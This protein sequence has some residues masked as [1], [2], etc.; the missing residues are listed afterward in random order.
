M[1]LRRLAKLLTRGG[2]CVGAVIGGAELARRTQPSPVAPA[3][4]DAPQRAHIALPSMPVS[5]RPPAANEE[6]DQALSPER[7]DHALGIDL[8][9][10]KVITGATE[11]RL[12]LF[13]FDDGPDRRTTPLLLDRLDAEGVKAVFFLAARRIRGDNLMQREQAEIAREIV[14]RG[15]MVANHTVDHQQLPLLHDDQVVQQVVGAERIFE[16]VLGGRPWLIRPPGGARS[17]RIDALLA[18]R[19]YT[20]VMWNLGS[21]DFQ[22]RSADQVFETWRRVFERRREEE[23][24]RGGIILLHDTYTWSVDAF[25]RIV[26]Y[27]RERNCHLLRQGEEL[28]DIVDDPALFFEPREDALPGS[29][30][31]PAAPPEDILEARQA[32]LRKETARRCGTLAS[33]HPPPPA[34]HGENA[35]GRSASR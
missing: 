27:L 23:G 31:A 21:G 2:L 15:H 26:A 25:Q 33:A 19:G 8:K 13:T 22:V 16:R 3:P 34:R 32:R 29:E 11:H 28:Y 18:E 10:G 5:R 1:L 30:A 35:P 6:R 4:S 24:E 20:T 9:N 17:Q 7:L 12:V 14:R